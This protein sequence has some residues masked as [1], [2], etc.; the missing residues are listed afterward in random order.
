MQK[1]SLLL[2]GCIVL[3]L[4]ALTVL[5]QREPV[6]MRPDAGEKPVVAIEKNEKGVAKK[7]IREGMTFQGIRGFFRQTGSR[8]TLYTVDENDRFVCLENLNLERILKAIEEK[9]ERS[10][11]KIDGTYTEFRGENFVLITR[12]VIS[13]EDFS[14]TV[15]PVELKPTQ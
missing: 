12:A 8:T 5:A 2:V 13:P 15:K 14:S 4:S 6:P 11:W 1:T 10:V 9:P 7:R 3:F